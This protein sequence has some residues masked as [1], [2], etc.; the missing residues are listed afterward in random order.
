MGARLEGLLERDRG[1]QAAICAVDVDPLVER[2]IAFEHLFGE[3]RADAG[4][5]AGASGVEVWK[6]V[7]LLVGAV[8]AAAALVKEK[9]SIPP[10]PSPEALLRLPSEGRD[11]DSWS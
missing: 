2:E 10:S 7:S 4:D 3:D 9:R 8:P 1:E 5:R 11:G 6:F